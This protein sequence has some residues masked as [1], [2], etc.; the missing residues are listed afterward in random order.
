MLTR[1]SLRWPVNA[2]ALRFSILCISVLCGLFALEIGLRFRQWLLKGTPFFAAASDIADEHLGWKGVEFPKLGKRRHPRLLVLG[3]SFTEGMGLDSKNLYHQLLAKKSRVQVLT[4]GGQGYGTLQEY[5]VLERLLPRFKPDL[6]V[7]QVCSN[8]LINNSWLLESQSY[9]QSFPIAR[10]YLEHGRVVHRYPRNY[11]WFRA[12]LISHFRLA[13][14]LNLRYEQYLVA[15]A[16][17]GS[18]HTIEE[19]IQKSGWRTVGFSEAVNT[20]QNLATMM[21]ALTS[22]P[23][24][25][26]LVDDAA[27]YTQ[28]LVSSFEKAGIPL[29]RAPARRLALAKRKGRAIYLADGAHFNSTGNA[30]L[31][32]VL[33]KSLLPW[34]EAVRHP[35]RGVKR[36]A[37]KPI[38]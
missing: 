14:K 33:S 2:I 3:D 35:G 12:Y 37:V 1:R 20:T 7:I 28:G 11:S 8:D 9:L 31:A 24:V 19:S 29:L 38:H 23:I 36:R 5:L 15:R 34:V 13:Y 4:Y 16:A 30:L 22:V 21:R 32:S 6:V 25:A 10:P 18:L 26:F 27:P 17:E